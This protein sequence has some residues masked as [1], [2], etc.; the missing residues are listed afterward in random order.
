MCLRDSTG[1]FFGGLA[2]NV[3]YGCIMIFGESASALL[4]VNPK[5]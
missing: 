4:S 1:T 3:R 2:C 5:P